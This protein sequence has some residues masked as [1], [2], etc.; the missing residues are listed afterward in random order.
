MFLGALFLIAISVWFVP[1]IERARLPLLCA[2]VLIIGT[3]FGPAFFSV[4]G[5]LL[6]SLD[7]VLFVVLCVVAFFSLRGSTAGLPQLT[8]SDWLVAIYVFWVFVSTLGGEPPAKTS[9]LGTWIFYVL[10]PAMIYGIARV[11]KIGDIDLR[12]L[13]T[14]LL[15]L[16]IYLAVTGFF[17]SRGWYSL[18]FPKYI[19]DPEH[20]EFFGRGRGPLLNPS[21]NGIVLT[22]GL[23]IAAV[24]W[25]RAGR[26]GRVGYSLA[27]L[28]MLAGIYAT[29]TRSV[30]IG[31]VLALAIVFWQVTPRW[32][33][34]LSLCAS[35][36]LAGLAVA[37][38]KEQLLRM[39]RDKNLSATEAEKSVQLR[40]LLAIVAYEMVKDAPFVGHGFGYY[41]KAARPYYTL[42]GYGLPLETARGYH[43]HNVLLSIV[44]NNGIIGLAL[45][46]LMLMIWLGAGWELSK[47]PV[48][49]DLWRHT[50][51]VVVASIAGYL[52]G[53]MFQDVTIMPMINMFLF[54]F[55]GLI[56]TLRQSI[57]TT[58]QSARAQMV[59][60]FNAR[61]NDDR[62]TAV[63][64][65]AFQPAAS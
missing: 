45:F 2:S 54:F 16:G 5:P 44:V 59:P 18:V 58:A 41:Q 64:G 15:A 17:E 20:W 65:G 36:L 4:Q 53:G 63:A 21:A 38:L 25:L 30:W 55:A 23:A 12:R 37:G 62:E 11:A 22:I 60:T 28:I 39:K 7:R 48:A 31:G 47:H 57:E 3:V 46:S 24:R 43:Q 42:R 1:L 8:K 33:K 27:I 51:L 40:P 6:I 29:L 32:V 50:G 9:P 34:V 10:L 61:L 19:A 56:V 49:N 35:I 14:A 13:E 26:G 52:V